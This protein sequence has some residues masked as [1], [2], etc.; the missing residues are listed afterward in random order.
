MLRKVVR[1]IQEKFGL[2]KSEAGVILF[3][4]FGLVLGGVA[5]FL[6]LGK[7]TERYDFSDS[8][9]FFAAASSKI[10]S[11]IAAEEDTGKSASPVSGRKEALATSPVDLNRAGLND[12]VAVPGIGS[13]TAQRIIDYRTANG[14]FTTVDDLL[15]V[16]GIG[17]K[18]LEQIK[19]YVRAD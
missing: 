2:T 5:K 1:I 19:R 11:A 6:D 8:D 14:R 7:S 3:L 9:S 4:A 10:D 13:V 12:L 17:A 16:K 18:K 15:K